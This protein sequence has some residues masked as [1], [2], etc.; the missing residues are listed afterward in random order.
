[1]ILII[2]EYLQLEIKTLSQLPWIANDKRAMYLHRGWSDIPTTEIRCSGK[3]TVVYPS[4]VF[5]EKRDDILQHQATRCNDFLA[6]RLLKIE[7][8]DAVPLFLPGSVLTWCTYNKISWDFVP[9]RSLAGFLRY[10]RVI[11]IL[12]VKTWTTLQ[13]VQC[14]L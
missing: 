13:I 12:A 7:A 9:N 4:F 11:S 3:W 14:T 8:I 6:D 10:G 2:Y 5:E 1:M